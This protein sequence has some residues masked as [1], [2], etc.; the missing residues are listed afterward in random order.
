ME[1]EVFQPPLTGVAVG[2]ERTERSRSWAGS[3]H[4]TDEPGDADDFGGSWRDGDSNLSSDDSDAASAAST[5]TSRHTQQSESK[6]RAVA[7]AAA[8]RGVARAKAAVRNPALDL[9]FLPTSSS[10]EAGADGGGG[11]GGGRAR[12]GSRSDVGVG[13]VGRARSS[14]SAGGGG[15]GDV[16]AGGAGDVGAAGGGVDRGQGARASGGAGRNQRGWP[17]P[18]PGDQEQVGESS[19]VHGWKR[20]WKGL[21]GSGQEAK[22]GRVDNNRPFY[23]RV[24]MPD[25]MAGV[26][27]P[28]PARH[29]P[30]CY[31]WSDFFVISTADHGRRT[32]FN[33]R[34][35]EDITWR[36]ASREDWGRRAAAAAA[37]GR[38]S[39]EYRDQ[40]GTGG[41]R[42]GRTL[43][44]QCPE[45]KVTRAWGRCSA[46]RLTFYAPYWV[47][48]K[49]GLALN[50]RARYPSKSTFRIGASAKSGGGSGQQGGG[51]GGVH[52]GGGNSNVVRGNSSSSGSNT[53][54]VFD[55]GVV[56]EG[57]DGRS[58]LGKGGSSK[59]VGVESSRKKSASMSSAEEAARTQVSRLLLRDATYLSDEE[60]LSFFGGRSLPVMLACPSRKLEV[61]PYAFA[62]RAEDAGLCVC[63]L[64]VDSD[65][66]SL[67]FCLTSPR[68][69]S[70]LYTDC[71]VTVTSFPR[72]IMAAAA[73]GA[74]PSTPR[75]TVQILTPWREPPAPEKEAFMTF[76]LTRD[77]LVHVCM[78]S[79]TPPGKLPSW[80]E[81]AGFRKLPDAE[82]HTSEPGL[83]LHVYRRFFRAR[84]LI[85]LGGSDN[86]RDLGQALTGLSGAAAKP[87]GPAPKGML[88]NYTVVLTTVPPPPTPASQLPPT[89]GPMQGAATPPGSGHAAHA[90]MAAAA[91]AAATYGEEADVRDALVDRDVTGSIVCRRRYRILPDF[92]PGDRPYVDRDYTIPSLPAELQGLRLTCVQT[93]QGDKRAGGSRLWR[94]SLMQESV[95]L[96][97][98]DARAQSVP[99]WLAASG[100]VL[101][102]GVRVA[103]AQY[104]IPYLY[105]DLVVSP[106]AIDRAGAE[107]GRAAGVEG[108]RPR[109]AS[110][111]ERQR[112]PAVGLRRRGMS[113]TDA[114]VF[115]S[116][117]GVGGG[118]TVVDG[119][120]GGG[121][122]RGAGSG[123]LG[124]GSAARFGKA[125]ER[126]RGGLQH[127][128]PLWDTGKDGRLSQMPVPFDRVGRSW[129]RTFNVD[130]AKTGGPLETSGATLGVSVS[131][132]TGQFHRTRV[133]TLYP[134][135]IVRN[136]LGFPLE[137]WRPF[138]PPT[139]AAVERLSQCIPPAMP[140]PGRDS[141]FLRAYRDSSRRHAVS[142]TPDGSDG[143]GRSNAGGDPSRAA[144]PVPASVSAN[145][146]AA[147]A[148]KGTD[149]LARTVPTSTAVIIY[150]FNAADQLVK[151]LATAA[152]SSS[153]GETH[154]WVVDSAGRRHLAAAF[155]SLQRATV[156]ITLS[157]SSQFPPFR[158]ENRSGAE[159]LA[160]R[161]VDAHRSMGWH[162][163]P[164][165]SWHAFLWQEPDKPRAIQMAFAS[166]LSPSHTSVARHSE[167]YSLDKIGVRDPL[168]EESITRSVI[169]LVA[170]GTKVKRLFSEVR[171]EGRT[172]VLSLGDVRLSNF[173]E[174]GHAD[175]V[176]RLKRLYNQL[177][178]GIRFAGLSFNVVECSTEGPCE[179]MS[180][181]VDSVTVAKR[182]GDNTVEL[183]VFHVQVDDMRRR[184]RMPV[185][186]Q[187]AD[188][189]FNSHL[190]E[191]RGWG[192]GSKGAVPCVRLLLDKEV[193]TIGMPH[194][195]SLDLELQQEMRANV[196]LEFVLHLLNLAGSLLPELTSEE[197]LAKMSRKKAKI[198]VR[199]TVPTPAKRD[200]S[201][202]YVEAFRHSTIVIRME[203][204]VGQAALEGDPEATAGGLTVLS[205]SFLTVLSVLGS[206]I[207]HVNPTFVFDE[208]VVTHYCGSIGGLSG[209]VVTAITQQAVA[210]GYKVV[211]S[212]ELLGD[213]LSL[214]SKLG[215]S[216]AQFFTKT[217]A[218]MTGDADTVG[219]GAKVLVKGL[220]GGTFGSAAKI[221]GSL[222][223][224]IRGLSGTAIADNEA[225][226]EH[227]DD[228]DGQLQGEVKDLEH[229]V[230]Q[231]GKVFY[232]TM[233]AG[234]TGL[235]DRPAEGAKEEG[236]AGFI[237]GMAKGIV[238][239]VAAPVAGALGAVS[240]VTEGV[241][242]STR[243]SDEKR[244]GRRRAAR[245]AFTSA[246][247][248]RALPP[249]TPSD[250]VRNVPRR[251]AT[252]W[253][254]S[255]PA[256]TDAAAPATV[257]AGAGTNRVRRD[258]GGGRG[259]SR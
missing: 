159:T 112:P 53:A 99:L 59:A 206:S 22:L 89:T 80:L 24:R 87:D 65:I 255:G 236:F 153:M 127:I 51:G 210:Q 5:A 212:M 258:G 196:D 96:I 259:G 148:V 155:V 199:H 216:V 220:V 92:G 209:L 115:D 33:S 101:W 11:R 125:S 140:P 135:L 30:P 226:T 60:H 7:S 201:M 161:Q 57:L 197:V 131:A 208:L 61:M 152:A 41:G 31:H 137:L 128:S 8:D 167:E 52:D 19:S 17:W 68:P 119:G 178:I 12:S 211:G 150:A 171:V 72:E 90:K 231:G 202:V 176:T 145:A 170:T 254:G 240:R 120:R 252:F 79:R 239:A 188:S 81:Y 142:E 45:I 164:P 146:G 110:R 9:F 183:Q 223:G 28:A 26:N 147:A 234:I 15:G 77:A 139:A 44:Q 221:T 149:H 36:T 248:G 117:A 94:L 232:E 251:F 179:V 204:W 27:Q 187:P 34:Q 243:L 13:V 37:A 227:G 203:L 21:I 1:V 121:G 39:W 193:A 132:L 54:G 222:E 217:K 133:V 70:S 173:D 104:R 129:S 224:M 71:G 83:T 160:Y 253:V 47:V 207:A 69:G 49:T 238:G 118:E 116:R 82:V 73:G 249:L 166:S 88:A 106:D 67:Y 50:Y 84:T 114:G 23:V 25:P 214:V 35:P 233:K 78:D 192:G 123:R 134:R 102:E 195:R 180:A 144:N 177:D 40:I 218:E 200:L 100:F 141:S 10:T 64:Q 157:A 103:G 191:G 16:G 3:G 75:S 98:F 194:L 189:G 126:S 175:S 20:V 63:D 38:G 230:K 162:I 246:S 14:S 182:S 244:M 95:V 66:S 158:V 105:K 250:L 165:L 151:G 113:A 108:S 85:K 225:G 58:A 256:S 184:S 18:N 86:S 46:R 42:E 235:I 241:D 205:G 181:H 257:E 168:E 163:L 198:A 185:V 4:D 213:P 91:A 111:H 169:T 215:D 74:A 32:F 138:L 245:T 190:R 56:G 136:F 93:A 29:S 186:L 6:A 229:G 43:R 228:D 172:R 130:A 247:K 143:A 107:S 237:A 154:L 122:G 242:A 124:V 156:F 48:N 55:G 174:D 97:I 62:A 2:A 219:A 76:W 109:A